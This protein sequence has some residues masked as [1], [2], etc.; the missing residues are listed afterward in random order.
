V[1]IGEV[2]RAERLHEHETLATGDSTM[3]VVT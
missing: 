1:G 3:K 2:R